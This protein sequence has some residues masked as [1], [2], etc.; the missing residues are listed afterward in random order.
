M[1]FSA[2][3]NPGSKSLSIFDAYLRF[4]QWG[5]THA[6]ITR[7]KNARNCWFAYPDKLESFA[8]MD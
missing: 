1:V 7:T 6:A 2:Y 8:M 3:M 4:R 5:E